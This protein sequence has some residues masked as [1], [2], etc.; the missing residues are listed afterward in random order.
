MPQTT[1]EA[2]RLITTLSPVER[3][4]KHIADEAELIDF[5]Q[6]RAREADQRRRDYESELAK[7]GGA[8]V[9]HN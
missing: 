4:E 6:R 7:L 3:L 8:Q 5:H 9:A 1:I 2:R